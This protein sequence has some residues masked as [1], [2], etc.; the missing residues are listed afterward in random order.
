MSA[1]SEFECFSKKFF[2]TE[3]FSKLLLKDK[4]DVFILF[5]FIEKSLLTKVLL[6]FLLFTCKSADFPGWIKLI[7]KKEVNINFFD[8]PEFNVT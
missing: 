5:N 2:L 8:I 6:S 4:L 1:Y 3:I 7:N